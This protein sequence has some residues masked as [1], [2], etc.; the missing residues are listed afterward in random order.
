M[1][2]PSIDPT[3][4]AILAIGGA[5]DGAFVVPPVAPGSLVVAADSGLDRLVAAGFPVHHV[6]G[7]LDSV[8][9]A[10][11]AVAEASGAAIH[12]HPADKD[13]TDLELAL[14]LVAELAADHALSHLLVIGSGGG[15][16]DHLVGDLAILAGPLVAEIDVTAHLDRAVVTVVRPGRSRSLRGEPG[17]L[18]SLQ[19]VHGAAA[20]VS[21][22]GLR[23]PLIDADLPAGSSRGTS[24]ELLE[25][26]ADVSLGSGVLLAIQPGCAAP[27]VPPRSTPYDP[28]PRTP[29][30]T[31]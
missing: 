14:A 11:L 15:R 24:N 18:V 1:S 30:G 10:S 23:W 16:I 31:P 26:R 4:S 25:S 9:A 19:P 8:D 3:P 22:E 6:V 28:T 27:P 12:R 5:A 2:D 13:A 29:R 7:D 20:G 17:E 21:T